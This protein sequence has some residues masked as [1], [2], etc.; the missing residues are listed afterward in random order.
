MKKIFIVDDNPNLIEYM[1][2]KLR[3]AG[4]EV[5]TESDGLAVVN[6]LVDYTPDVVFIDYFLPNING[7]KL[8]KII[9]KM[10]HLKNTYLVVM[11]AAAK[12]MQL[13]PSKVCADALIAKGTFKETMEHFFFAI[14]DSEKPRKDPVDRGVMGFD[15]IYPSRMTV[16]L[17]E[18]YRHLQTMLDSISEGIIEVYRGQIVYANPAA[19]VIFDNKKDQLLTAHPS[20][21]F[22]SSEQFKV[23]S[24]MES[25]LN[26][27]V[28][29][30]R[31]GPVRSEDRVLSIRKLPLLGERDTII[32]LVADITERVRTEKTLLSYQDHLEALVDERTAELKQTAEKLHQAQK[33]EAIGTFAGGIAH[34][35][36][37]ILTVLIGFGTLLKMG[38]EEDSPLTTYVDEML[39]SSEKAARLTRS[40]LA[41]TRKQPMVMNSLSLN[42][43]IES[44]KKLLK[45]LLT[46]D[47]E[48]RTYLTSDGTTIMGDASQI[49]QILINLTT[50]ARD[51]MP[52]GGVL[53]IETKHLVLDGEFEDVHGY[54][55]PGEYVLVSVSDTGIGMDAETGKHIFDPFFTTKEVGKGTGLG[56]STVYGIV[57]QH[58]GYIHVVSEPGAGTTFRIYLPFASAATKEEGP[59]SSTVLTGG[60]ETILVAE[61]NIGVR[62]FL[63]M[64]LSRYGYTVIEAIDGKDAI[65]KFKKYEA[66][67]LLIVDSVMPK[68][69]GKE[70]YD[71]IRKLCPEVKVLFTSGYTKDVIID[72]GLK[73]E[74]FHFL[75]KPITPHEVL[76]KVREILD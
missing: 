50:N 40:L 55:K 66:I 43:T 65:D 34:D 23:K 41:F 45:R 48:L 71:E 8:C 42:K 54:G 67:D 1:G 6:R 26:E 7:D 31:K 69:N 52:Q 68:R 15:S 27:S 62:N 25:E 39:F 60:N 53:I 13:D 59:T 63:K 22:D 64:T 72:K 18:K 9:R 58:N 12:E 44:T 14:A 32:L 11:S 28:V 16:E 17:L 74:E 10:E 51:A 70:A 73:E 38:L 76:K 35:F 36:N 37:N 30:D 49:D 20:S 3:D 75:P 56:L 46:E 57:R 29:V 24:L 4:H 19:M 61:D 21:L 5:V 47:I 2:K 33:M